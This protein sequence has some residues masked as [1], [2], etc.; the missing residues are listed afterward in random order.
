MSVEHPYLRAAID[1]EVANLASAAA[2]TRN[3]TLFKCAASLASLGLREGE[4]LQ[5]LKPAAETIGLRGRE[6]YTTVKSGLKAGNSRPREIPHNNGWVPAP[7]FENVA[8][9]NSASRIPEANDAKH[10][11]AQPIFIA[12]PGGPTASADEIRRHIY[13][14]HGLA[15]RMKIK[16]RSGGYVNWYRVTRDGQDGWQPAKPETYAC[17]PYSG[18]VDPLDP[19]VTDQLLYWPEGEKDCDTLGQAGLPALTFGGTGDGL[20]EG[21]AE[22]LRGRHVVI[23]AD[24]DAGGQDHALRKAAVAYP[25]AKTVKLIQFPELSLKGDV[26]DYLQAASAADLERRV[27]GTQLWKPTVGKSQTDWRSSVITASDL[28]SRTFSP[29]KFVV[30]G[31]I[32]EGVTIFAGKPKIGKSWLLYDVCLASAA[33]RFV[34]GEIKPTQGDVLYLALEDSERRLKKRLEKLWPG[35]AWPARL[36]LATE[37]RK[38]DAGGLDDLAEWCDSV[39][40]PVLIVVD[41]LEKIRP[42]P[43]GN[44]AAYSTD[45]VAI[46][47]LHKLA[48]TRGIAVVVIH[49]VRKMEADDPF[50]MVSGTNGL[51]GAADTILV[52]KRQAGNVTLYARGRDIEEQET[53][54]RFD[55]NTCRWTFLGEA[56]AVHGSTE[57]A[58]IVAALIEASEEGMHISEIMVAVQ[59]SDRNAVYQLLFKMERNGEVV[60][61]KRGQYALAGKNDKKVRSENNA[62]ER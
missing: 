27:S 49:H 22:Y 19:T 30:P 23:L 37:W 20:P 48:H 7:R 16:R 12:G 59:R 58:S 47:G 24:N 44:A 40:N 2:G 31:Y 38:A 45:Y 43:K 35:G 8:V 25:V 55:K 61:I 14:R 34:L 57:R 46:A 60:R 39:P 13:R 21:A 5:L 33:D 18:D 26:S 3:Q 52:L 1:G 32:P 4:I 15:V 54:C 56:G 36:K 28:K 6:L 41:T 10:V 9:P 50:D 17:C 29:V 62:F 53:A 42:T 11:G 51:T